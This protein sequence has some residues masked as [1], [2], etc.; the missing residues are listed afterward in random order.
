MQKEGIY[1]E[2]SSPQVNRSK[3]A[4]PPDWNRITGVR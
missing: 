3:L 4:L 2:T 1:F